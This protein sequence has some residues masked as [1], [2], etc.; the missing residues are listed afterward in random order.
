[1]AVKK[2]A[3]TLQSNEKLHF[4]NG[5]NQFD[6]GKEWWG[7]RHTIAVMSFIGLVVSYAMRVNLSIAI[8]AMVG[9]GVKNATRFIQRNQSEVCPAPY[10]QSPELN[11]QEQIRANAEFDWDEE[12]QGLLL[13]AFF[14]G[15]STTNL[16]GGLAAERFGGRLAF[17]WSLILSSVFCVL[18]PICARLS[19]V[20]FIAIR[21]LTG[22]A[23]GGLFPSLVV[24]ISTWVSPKERS[25]FTSFIYA[26]SNL[27]TVV[28]MSGGGWLCSSNL[29]GGWP[30][31]FYASGVLGF[32]CGIPWFVLVH[33]RHSTHPRVSQK[34]IDY[35]AQEKD[36]VRQQ[37]VNSVPWRDIAKSLP[38]WAIAIASFGNNFGFHTLLSG[39]PLYFSNILFFDLKE[40]GV[41]S[42]LPYLGLTVV[43]IFWGTL[44]D[45]CTH[46][47]VFSIGTVRKLSAAIG[48]YGQVVG[49]I[50]MYFL[51]C[52]A[53][54]ALCILCI[55]MAFSGASYCGYPVSN[56]D[57]APNLCGTLA[58]LT[59][60]VGALTGILAPGVT[61]LIIQG[62]QTL[63]AW[64]LVF[65]ISA[66][67]VFIS[68]TF[69]VVF[70][71]NQIQPWN[72]IEFK[73]KKNNVSSHA[74]SEKPQH[75]AYN[76]TQTEKKDRDENSEL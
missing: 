40:N 17:G 71:T 2:I 37:M 18:S 29:F 62:N 14:W 12:T 20:L 5:R 9:T 52:D 10:A 41:L 68:T 60:T 70:S 23:Q 53:F 72:A 55:T 65:L 7:C 63:S 33:D 45:I 32:A 58:G 42:A 66:V 76:I 73:K 64:R 74:S 25:K 6:E 39:L 35:I 16:L 69:F 8:V 47:N 48:G 67:V 19:T 11:D 31:I 21:L 13:G 3:I 4:E 46:K 57:I 54:L 1:M 26:G 59:N 75:V 36:S 44:M 27:G 34:E 56:Q 38:F 28:A 50:S 30:S 24:L 61:G 49:L 22:A 43:I 15:Y 51:G